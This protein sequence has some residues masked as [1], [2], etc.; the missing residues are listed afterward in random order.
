MLNLLQSLF[1]W[2][3][4]FKI[5]EFRKLFETWAARGA[6]VGGVAWV[7]VVSTGGAEDA[8]HTLG[9]LQVGHL[10]G[11]F[12]IPSPVQLIQKHVLTLYAFRQ[13][14][15]VCI[16]VGPL[17]VFKHLQVVRGSPTVDTV[18]YTW[19]IQ[20]FIGVQRPPFTKIS[21][22]QNIKIYFVFKL[23][24]NIQITLE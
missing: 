14:L 23:W 4:V 12:I 9:S 15:R 10:V 3:F 11:A 6:D 20:N 7:V 19:E 8:Q 18:Q 21:S 24:I 1:P 13:T 5:A 16:R 17:F 2:C 22:G